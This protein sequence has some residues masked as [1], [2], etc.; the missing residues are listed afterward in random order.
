MTVELTTSQLLLRPMTMA[1]V[2]AIAD[3]HTNQ[4]V[5]AHYSIESLNTPDEK[6][7]FVNR[8]I[9]QSNIIW[10]IRLL[11]A[12]EIIIGDCALHHYCHKEKRIEIGGT[13]LPM[14]WNKAIM[15]EA[16]NAIMQ[17]ATTA[18]NVEAFIAKTEKLNSR[19]LKFAQKM[20]FTIEVEN[21]NEVTLI[22]PVDVQF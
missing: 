11:K 16:F 1:D 14:Y 2:N 8:I 6:T 17:Y 5:A 21:L 4:D 15:T 9:V 13:L 3:L 20:G 22:K 7:C 18:Y 19:A 10:T 12:R